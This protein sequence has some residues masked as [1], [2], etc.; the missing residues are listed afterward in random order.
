MKAIEYGKANQ[1]VIIFLHGG[2]LSWWNYRKAAERL[3]DRFHVVIPILDGHTG[4][5]APFTTIEDNAK[6]I[7]TY[8]DEHFGGKVLLI[9][10]LSLG[11]QILVD[12]LSQR[13]SICEFAVVESAL[14][15]PM[16]WTS[17]MIEPVFSLFYPLVKKRWFARMQFK[18]LHMDAE[19]FEEYYADSAG[20]SKKDLTAI[21]KANSGY[22]I[23]QSLGQCNAKALVAVGEREKRIMKRS[24]GMIADYISD[25]EIL[26]IKGYRHGEL[27][28]N[29]SDRYVKAVLN[30]MKEP[31]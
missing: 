10:G 4:S 19:Y 13:D 11:A 31:I 18:S 2:G 27:S 23:K 12:I 26:F 29:H 14:V 16:K 17:C 7:I 6:E 25:S 8:I 9:G 5:D 28:I 21:L 3:K 22:S 24:A 20:I 30:L 15:L 1:S